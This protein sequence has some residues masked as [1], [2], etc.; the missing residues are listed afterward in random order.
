M[1]TDSARRAGGQC[2]RRMGAAALR[3]TALVESTPA[4]TAAST[5]VLS[6]L[7]HSL[8]LT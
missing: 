7:C 3:G 4:S 6:T 2:A 5:G 1:T 8:L